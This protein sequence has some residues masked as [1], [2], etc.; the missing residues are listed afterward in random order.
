MTTNSDGYLLDTSALLALA[1][2]GHEFH[3]RVQGWFKDRIGT[4]C[5]CPI[6]QSA[7]IRATMRLTTKPT[8]AQAVQELQLIEAMARHVFIPD[9]LPVSAI[10]PRG[11]V[12]HQQVTDA[13]LAHLARHHNLKLATLDRAQ[14]A[15]FPDVAELIA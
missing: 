6:T 9:D 7:L 8:F 14:A 10:N 4:I 5:T 1:F 15:L 12:G 3:G 2:R 11:I 13:Y